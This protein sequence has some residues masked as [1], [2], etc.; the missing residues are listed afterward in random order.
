[1]NI[2][3]KQILAYSL[4]L[5]LLTFCVV[6]IKVVANCIDGPAEVRFGFP[7][8]WI[9]PGPTSLSY[10]IDLPALG[11]D[12]GVYL[13]AWV[14]LTQI[15]LFQRVFLWRP[16]LLSACLWVAAFGAAGFYIV[17]ISPDWYAGGVTFDRLSECAEVIRHALHLGPPGAA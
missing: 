13:G 3:T 14:L 11:I 17:M 6:T 16:R 8:A 12:F 9:T 4:P 15:A 1:M 2:G 10:K 5:A 7:L